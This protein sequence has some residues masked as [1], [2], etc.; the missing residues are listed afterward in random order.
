MKQFNLNALSE[1]RYRKQFGVNPTAIP[2]NNKKY[3][4]L[5][6]QIVAG[7]A[8]TAQVKGFHP[9]GQLNNFA[10]SGSGNF[11]F[12]FGNEL[13]GEEIIFTGVSFVRGFTLE[14]MSFS[15]E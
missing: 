15:K 6:T 1:S 3:V 14:N 12:E 2:L 4:Y 5:V 10:I 9:D 11:Q 13:L 7:G 8:W